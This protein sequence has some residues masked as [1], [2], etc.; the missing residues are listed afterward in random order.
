MLQLRKRVLDEQVRLKQDDVPAIKQK[1]ENLQQLAQE[2]GLAESKRA[3]L[4]QEIDAAAKYLWSIE[5]MSA[6]PMD[7]STRRR[8]FSVNALVTVVPPA[9]ELLAR[10]GGRDGAQAGI[11]GLIRRAGSFLH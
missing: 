9:I 4:H 10:F 6:W 5:G 3:A 1:I 11:W 8:Y 7:A 2:E